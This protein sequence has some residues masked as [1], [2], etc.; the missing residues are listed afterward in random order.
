MTS[1][2]ADRVVL[3]GRV[4][5]VK[6]FMLRRPVID[7]LRR[8]AVVESRLLGTPVPNRHVGNVALMTTRQPRELPL[9]LPLPRY[10]FFRK[11]VLNISVIRFREKISPFLPLRSAHPMQQSPFARGPGVPVES[12]PSPPS[13]GLRL[14]HPYSQ[15]LLNQRF[16]GGE[17]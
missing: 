9:P 16:E 4:W 12:V 3:H 2:F 11:Q 8:I 15:R 5:L 17:G 10:Q 1:H 7:G 6:A 13:P 14:G